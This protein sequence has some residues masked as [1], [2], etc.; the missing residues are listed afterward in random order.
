[1]ATA[2]KTL[3][4]HITQDPNICSGSAC[5]EGTRIRVIDILALHEDGLS[6]EEIV[7]EYPTLHGTVDVY[8]ALVYSHDHKA[9]VDADV[10]EGARMAEEAERERLANLQ[11]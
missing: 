9:E 1:M 8:A 4:P 7:E 10:E 3:Y 6:A 2:A 5:V 11:R